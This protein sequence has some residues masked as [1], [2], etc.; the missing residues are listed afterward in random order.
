MIATFIFG[1]MSG[2]ILYLY[3]HTGAEA[4]PNDSYVEEPVEGVTII[5]YMYGGCLEVGGCPSYRIA[6]D[7]TYVYISRNRGEEERFEDALTG[8]QYDLLRARLASTDMSGVKG[9]QFTGACPASY[10]DI[11]YRYEITYGGEQYDF[12]SCGEDL[13]TEPLFETLQGYF[14]VFAAGKGKL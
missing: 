12:D 4:D 3:N 8:A 7:G 11:A 14:E 9:T 13:E 6:E 5:A 2:I 10:N 1:F